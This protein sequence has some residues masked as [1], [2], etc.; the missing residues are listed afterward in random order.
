[1]TPLL[2]VS[3]L[4][5]GY[6]DIEILHGV[7]LRVP[8]GSVV[9]VLGANGVGKTTLLRTI[10]GEIEPTAGTI[11]FDGRPITGLAPWDVAGRGLA[12]IPEGRG[13]FPSMTVDDNLQVF[14]RSSR[15]DPARR[16]EVLDLFP[17]L[18]ERLQQL[19]GTLSGGEQQMLALSRSF[20]ARPRLLLVDELSSGLAPVIVE[21]LF[22]RLRDL[23]DAG[24][25]IVL[26]EQYLHHVSGF[27]DICYRVASGRVVFVGEPGELTEADLL[28]SGG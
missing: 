3:G 2:E 19:A 20:L 28:A 6:G 9:A 16:D 23:R 21:S 24:V 10:A 26:V 5:A 12:L 15:A 17:R 14:T 13:V 1:M 27:A 18:R 8:D 4:R 7:D 11:T 22:E 25:T